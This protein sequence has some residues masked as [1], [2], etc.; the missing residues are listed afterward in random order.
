MEASNKLQVSPQVP[1][2]R[3]NAKYVVLW[4]NF[5]RGNPTTN[6][7]HPKFISCS[8]HE[9]KPKDMRLKCDRY[10]PW[11][12][13]GRLP[14]SGIRHLYC[15]STIRETQLSAIRNVHPRH[16]FM[17]QGLHSDVEAH[18]DRPGGYRGKAEREDEK[19][20]RLALSLLN[21]SHYTTHILLVNPA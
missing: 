11:T 12:N 20:N 4:F 14:L 15:A 17:I 5:E 19:G 10:D 8:R 2:I 13:A 3:P 21:K 6:T 16:T 9:L 1:R 18:I 7:L